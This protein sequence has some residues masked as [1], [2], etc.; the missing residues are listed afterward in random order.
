M[1]SA[2]A[3]LRNAAT[4]FGTGQSQDFSNHPQ[5]GHF[6]LSV[7]FLDFAIH[8]KG[9]HQRLQVLDGEMTI[10]LF[11]CF[12]F[13]GVSW[14]LEFFSQKKE[15]E[16]SCRVFTHIHVCVNSVLFFEHFGIDL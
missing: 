16:A 10:T 14:G 13:D 7:H 5:Q 4:K 6:W 11:C 15:A 12:R 3:A 2:S 9:I 8:V 1:H